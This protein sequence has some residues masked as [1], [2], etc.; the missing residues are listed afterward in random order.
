VPL[1]LGMLAHAEGKRSFAIERLELAIS[2][3]QRAGLAFCAVSSSVR[4]A[5]CLMASPDATDRRRGQHLARAART[6]AEEMEAVSLE[7]AAAAL[8]AKQAAPVT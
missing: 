5:E 7:K 3:S 1:L 8:L 4:L 2:M 6:R